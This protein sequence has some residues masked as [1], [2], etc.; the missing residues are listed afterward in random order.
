MRFK[1]KWCTEYKTWQE[2]HFSVARCAQGKY[3]GGMSDKGYDRQRRV[4]TSG[5]Y[6]PKSGEYEMQHFDCGDGN[7]KKLGLP[8]CVVLAVSVLRRPTARLRMYSG[9]G[10]RM[11]TLCIK[12]RLEFREICEHRLH[13][14]MPGRLYPG[15]T[16]RWQ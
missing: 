3:Q 7:E 9:F 16:N 15:R 6:N 14:R 10:C 1:R 4:M 8:Q 5:H 13:R 11:H 12:H 2:K